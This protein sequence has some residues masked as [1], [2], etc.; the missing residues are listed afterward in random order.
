MADVNASL[1]P[2]DPDVN[3]IPNPGDY[4]FQFNR[5]YLA[6][7]PNPAQGPI[8]WRVSDPDEYPCD[9]II[10]LPPDTQE[11]IVASVAPLMVTDTGTSINYYLDISAAQDIDVLDPEN[12]I[13]SVEGQTDFP[14]LGSPDDGPILV[15]YDLNDKAAVTSF[16][17]GRLDSLP[18]INNRSLKVKAG[19]YNRNSKSVQKFTADLPIE[20][21]QIDSLTELS[22]NINSLP[23][24]P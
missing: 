11:Y 10:P 17:F 14:L 16:A 22:L 15:V 13:V 7:N 20:T 1:N 6:I 21:D 23:L 24:A 5:Y 18:D 9:S 3:I 12:I 19:A 4:V 2:V 8:T